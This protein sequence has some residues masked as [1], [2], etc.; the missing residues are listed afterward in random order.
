MKKTG[1]LALIVAGISVIV[2]IITRLIQ[3]PLGLAIYSERM[4]PS[5]YL[6]FAITFILF[7]IAFILLDLFRSY[8]K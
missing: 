7:A 2:A 6:L 8:K 5:E 4:K 3:Q 1:I